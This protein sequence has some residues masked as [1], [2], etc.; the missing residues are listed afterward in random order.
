MGIVDMKLLK[1]N[2]FVLE[3]ILTYYLI[4]NRGEEL[5]KRYD[6]YVYI[7]DNYFYIIGKQL[8]LNFAQEYIK[9]FDFYAQE[10]DAKYFYMEGEE[11]QSMY[12]NEIFGAYLS[13][14]NEK[15]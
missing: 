5:Y 10:L 3:G 4:Q 7:N 2:F 13:N 12:L 11:E 6:V 9:L 15:I 14:I 8:P 1:K